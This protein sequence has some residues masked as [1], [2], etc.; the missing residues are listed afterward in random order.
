MNAIT[1]LNESE[2]SNILDAICFVLGLTDTSSV[3]A[4]HHPYAWSVQFQSPVHFP[5]LMIPFRD[6]ADQ[7]ET[8]IASAREMFAD[9]SAGVDKIRGELKS[10]VDK[11]TNGQVR[12][13]PQLS[14]PRAPR[15]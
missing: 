6:D 1:G 10:L 13:S 15:C 3:R 5:S 2:K 7:I 4:P 8:G 9:A 12:T 11:V 14:Q